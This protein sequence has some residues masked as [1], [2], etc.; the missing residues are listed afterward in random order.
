MGVQ[1]Q[2]QRRENSYNMSSLKATKWPH[3]KTRLK[4]W[5]Q[6]KR[7]GHNEMQIMTGDSLFLKAAGDCAHEK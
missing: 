5:L 1:N 6:E 7:V 2:N 3:S 4:N